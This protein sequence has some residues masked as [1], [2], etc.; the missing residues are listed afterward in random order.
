MQ[1]ETPR[2]VHPRRLS[3]ALLLCLSGT[4]LATGALVLAGTPAGAAALATASTGPHTPS[5]PAAQLST[6]MMPASSPDAVAARA[7]SSLAARSAVTAYATTSY[8]QGVDVADYQHPNGA[9]ITWTSVRASG[10]SFAIVKATESTDYVNSYVT[11][12][13]AGARAAGL[14]VGLYHFARP[15][16]TSGSPLPDAAAEAD[17]FAA[18]VKAVGGAQLPP[19]LDLE[20]TGGLTPAQLAQW[21]GAFLT[22]VQSDT[23]RRPMIYTGPYFW[24]DDVASTAFSSYPL[25]E[26]DYTTAAAPMTFGGWSGWSLWQYSDGSYGSPAA[27][28]GISGDVDRS[29]FYSST[30]TL[31]TFAS[32]STGN[33]AP[34][35]GTASAASFPNGTLVQVAGSTEVYQIAGLAPIYLTTFNDV[36]SRTVH[37][38]SQAQFDT[39]RSSPVDGTWLCSHDTGQVYRVAGGAPLYITNF[40]PYAGKVPPLVSISQLDLTQAGQPGLWD[41]LLFRPVDGTFIST[42]ETGAVYRIAGGAPVYVSSW[43]YFGGGQAAAAVNAATIASA[44]STGGAGVFEHMN[45]LPTNGTDIADPT[46]GTYWTTTSGKLTPVSNAGQPFVVEGHTAIV[47]AGQ[48][49]VWSHLL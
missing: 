13:S 22:R 27:V 45:Y 48:A 8:L 6:S 10:Q 31:A 47:Y 32:S 23:G 16:L 29:R 38:L 36:T 9:A 30:A 25:W 26:A 14:T 19:T 40:A 7:E 11:S 21:T 35:T 28:P 37:Q 33:V 15:T 46:A 43:S 39:L 44:G 41:H 1:R 12:D 34:F 2:T 17:H 42:A 3:L 5:D 20:V 4:A 24:D 18:Q 49:G